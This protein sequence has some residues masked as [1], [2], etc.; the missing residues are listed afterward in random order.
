MTVHEVAQELYTDLTSVFLPNEYGTWL[1][2][3]TWVTAARLSLSFQKS[4]RRT[5]LGLRPGSAGDAQG[6][7]RCAKCWLETLP[8]CDGRS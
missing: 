2:K 3:H 6:L 5:E 7:R 8:L 4:V 1:L